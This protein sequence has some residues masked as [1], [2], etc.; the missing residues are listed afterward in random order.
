[1][2]LVTG[3]LLGADLVAGV[4][5]KERP[6]DTLPQ[7]CF[8][9]AVVAGSPVTVEASVEASRGAVAV[10]AAAQEDFAIDLYGSLDGESYFLIERLT[11]AL[12]VSG[13]ALLWDQAAVCCEL[14]RLV[15]STLS[16]T[17]VRVCGAV[18]GISA[19]GTR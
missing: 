9:V 14:F 4:W 15:V 12:L 19:R 6:A 16:E 11:P 13:Y 5:V 8:D 1:M 7:T 2:T 18:G 10:A 17:E 3:T